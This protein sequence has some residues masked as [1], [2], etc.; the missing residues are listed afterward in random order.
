[1][2]VPLEKAPANLVPAAAVIR[3]VLALFGII[4]RK[5]CVDGVFSLLLNLSA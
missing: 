1:M 5:G 2:M 3:E 4:G